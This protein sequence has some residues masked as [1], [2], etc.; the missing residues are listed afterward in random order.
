MP[1][2][3]QNGILTVSMYIYTMYPIKGITAEPIGSKF[4]VR[5]HMTPRKGYAC[6]KL[7]KC[8]YKVFEFCKIWKRPDNGWF[9]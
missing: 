7:Q 3:I 5:P 8:V 9:S 6:S 1:S 4:C 2:T